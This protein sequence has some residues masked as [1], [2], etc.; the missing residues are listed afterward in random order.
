S[1]SLR[2]S[3]RVKRSRA[4]RSAYAPRETLPRRRTATPAAQNA[5]VAN[6]RL[7]RARER[8]RAARE[9]LRR[10]GA[11]PIGAGLIGFPRSAPS[12]ID[13]HEA[14]PARPGRVRYLYRD[15]PRLPAADL[16]D[17]R[18]PPDAGPRRPGAQPLHPQVGGA[19]GAAGLPR[20]LERPVLLPGA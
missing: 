7:P 19:P 17:L 10:S 2:H 11:P 16:G 5:L 15:R 4:E 12:R 3:R 20:P 6:V 8:R 13:A 18:R 14:P 9:A 1:R